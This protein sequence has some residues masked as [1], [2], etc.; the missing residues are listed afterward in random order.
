MRNAASNSGVAVTSVQRTAEFEGT[1]MAIASWSEAFLARAAIRMGGLGPVEKVL[2]DP[3][4]L[5]A[6]ET[7]R[8]TMNRPTAATTKALAVLG[9]QLTAAEETE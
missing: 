9:A 2:F 6:L 7:I 5:K 8:S 4:S 1:A 3:D